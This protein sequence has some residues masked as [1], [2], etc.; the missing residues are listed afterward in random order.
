MKLLAQIGT[1]YHLNQ[2]PHFLH[3]YRSLGVER[4]ICALHGRRIVEARRVLAGYPAE[5]VVTY[6]AMSYERLAGVHWRENFNQVRRQHVRPDEWCLYADVDEFHQY[7]PDFFA[8]LDPAVNVVRGRR[9]E[10]LATADGQ[11][12][13]CRPAGN[14]GEQFPIATRDLFCAGRAHVIATRRDQEIV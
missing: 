9:L 11:L 12:Q 6:G 5:I 8:T 2:L 14:I 13:A 1:D 10:R 7:P 4:F 3:H